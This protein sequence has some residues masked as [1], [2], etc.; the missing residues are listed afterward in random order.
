MR[1]L[2]HSELPIPFDSPRLEDALRT[3]LKDAHDFMALRTISNPDVVQRANALGLA[4][5]LA[6]LDEKGY[7]VVHDAFSTE[8][9]DE[10]REEAHRNHDSAPPDVGFRATMLLKRGALWEEA[11]I[12]PWVLARAE[13]LL[14]RG[15]LIYQSDSII[16]GPGLT[17]TQDCMRITGRHG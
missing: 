10:L 6:E 14:G 7:T 15:C 2:A 8:F 3:V 17:P 12:H 11:V 9:A 16:K 13:Y 4:K 1:G 5:N